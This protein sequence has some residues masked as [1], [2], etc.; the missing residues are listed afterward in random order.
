MTPPS[1]KMAL[2]KEVA[3]SL[4]SVTKKAMRPALLDLPEEE[5]LLHEFRM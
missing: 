3:F 2:T 5:S 4:A 1:D